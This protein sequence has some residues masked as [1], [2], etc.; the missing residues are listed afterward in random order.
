MKR[1]AKILAPLVLAMAGAAM[2]QDSLPVQ[3]TACLQI[4]GLLQRLAC[5]DRVAHSVGPVPRSAP[6]SRP[7]MQTIP[8]FASAA[9][10][11]AYVAPP[12]AAAPPAGLG[13]ERL[14]RAA[15]VKRASE[16]TASVAGI[17]YDPRGRFTVT[18]D[19]GEVWRQLEG[20]T[21]RLDAPKNFTVRI[22]RGALGSYDLNV[23]GRN[24]TYR[25][26]RLQ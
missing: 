2:A 3:L 5:Y 23:V 22:S 9:P 21:G 17:S 4:T 19:N 14:R 24:A 13:S 1:T 16:M 7:A 6:T 10:P 8:P 18:L 11:A 20:D 12:I 15:P 25:V 26:L